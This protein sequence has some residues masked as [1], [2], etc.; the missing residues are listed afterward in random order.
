MVTAL[1]EWT[2]KRMRAW[3][4]IVLAEGQRLRVSVAQQRMAAATDHNQDA[5]L[6]EM[7]LMCGACQGRGTGQRV[8][9]TGTPCACARCAKNYGQPGSL[10]QF[11]PHAGGRC[12]CSAR[13]HPHHGLG[14]RPNRAALQHHRAP[15]INMARELNAYMCQG[16][17]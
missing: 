4:L 7:R 3:S 2:K 16:D 9:Q 11:A 14:T 6:R 1:L 12:H 8:G 5:S 10:P 15:G 17:S 13:V